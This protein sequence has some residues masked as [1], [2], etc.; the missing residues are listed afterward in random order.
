[1]GTEADSPPGPACYVVVFTSR[2][3]GQ[4]ADGYAQAA[5]RMEQLVRQQ[6][7]FLGLQ[8]AHGE[9][10]VGITVSW[11][12]DLEAIDNWRRQPEHLDVQRRG[13]TGWYRAYTTTVCRV[14]RESHFPPPGP[15]G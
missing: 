8:S 5:A 1:M 9:D 2:R 13:R 3:T 12:T 10:G 6:P 7:G 4:D 14:E 11:W 15:R